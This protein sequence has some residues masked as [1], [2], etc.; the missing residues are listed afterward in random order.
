MGEICLWEVL[1]DGWTGLTGAPDQSDRCPPP[2]VRTKTRSRDRFRFVKGFPYEVR[3][4]QPINIR[5]HDRLRE[6]I[7][8]I[9]L[10][11]FLPFSL[12]PKLFQ[13]ITCWFS[14]VST[15]I[16]G[17][18]GGP[19]TLGQPSVCRS[20]AMLLERRSKVLRRFNLATSVRSF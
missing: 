6:P 13:S 15:S 14:F 5:G 8:Q 18:L 1:H 9:N 2:Q 16:E 20:V 11:L 7:D 3:P 12:W 17:V 4:S 10:F 19:P